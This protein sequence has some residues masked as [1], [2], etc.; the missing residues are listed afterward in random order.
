[1]TLNGP[2]C[3]YPCFSQLIES[4][5]EEKDT[6]D[7]E[8]VDAD[9]EPVSSEFGLSPIAGPSSPMACSPLQPP[10]SPDRDSTRD[11]FSDEEDVN[12]ESLGT[13]VLSLSLLLIPYL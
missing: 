4:A 10:P 12:D 7:I 1:M 11:M 6:V 9:P 5:A 8:E 3:Y 2:S 13:R